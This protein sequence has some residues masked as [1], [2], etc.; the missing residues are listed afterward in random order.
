M[1]AQQKTWQDYAALARTDFQNKAYESCYSNLLTAHQLH[2]YHQGI[3]YQKGVAEALTGRIKE[4]IHSLKEAILIQSKY[5]LDIPELEPL[6]NEPEFQKLKLL[7]KDLQNTII[8]SDT[9]AILKDRQLHIES[10]AV[11]SKTGLLYCTSIHKRK[12]VTI[13]KRGETQDLLD[14]TT[15]EITAP[16]GIKVNEQKNELWIS[17]SPLP[18]MVNYDSAMRSAVYRVDLRTKKITATYTPRTHSNHIL[19][20]L[21]VGPNDQLFTSDSRNNIIYQV[22]QQ[23]NSLEEFYTNDQFWNIQG[24]TFSK[25]GDYMFIADYIKG[26]FRLDMKSKSLIHITR[27]V[28]Q[29]L[30][31]IDGLLFYNNSL[32]AI[33]NGVSPMRVTQY[34]LNDTQ[35]SIINYTIIDRNHPAFNEPTNGFI[36]D[37]KLFYVANSQW[38]GYDEQHNPKPSETLQDII[39]LMYDLR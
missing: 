1:F 24:I 30:K 37:N 9:A 36:S 27:D 3:L 38:S 12:I 34:D 10:I 21:S 5:N 26:I 33:Q 4:S 18:E 20:D 29:S 11:G 8:K 35:D 15:S 28:D 39:I 6:K 31:S 7:Q 23:N 13:N 19:G 2:P 14:Y 17:A 32:I 25:N 22:N 16:L